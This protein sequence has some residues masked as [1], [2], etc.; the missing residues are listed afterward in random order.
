[1][2]EEHVKRCLTSLVIRKMELKSQA[3]KT[4]PPKWLK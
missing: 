4:Q 1:M 2:A 3:A